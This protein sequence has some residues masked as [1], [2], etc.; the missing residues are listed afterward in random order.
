RF[1]FRHRLSKHRHGNISHHGAPANGVPLP[2]NDHQKAACESATFPSAVAL[3]TATFVAIQPTIKGVDYMA[4][5]LGNLLGTVDV[6]LGT[7]TGVLGGGASGGA[8][9]SASGTAD[10]SHT[11]DLGA[12]IE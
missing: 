9:A 4:A 10:L 7:A 3:C 11:L 6:V 1:F 2:T 12:V 8:S 5:L